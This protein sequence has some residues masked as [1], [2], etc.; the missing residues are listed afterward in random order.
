MHWSHTSEHAIGA[1]QAQDLPPLS[2]F[3]QYFI[4]LKNVSILPPQIDTTFVTS[5][6][7]WSPGGFFE[8]IAGYTKTCVCK[9]IA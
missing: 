9:R 2:N 7:K 5:N 8:V 4:N 3:S 6:N 1:L